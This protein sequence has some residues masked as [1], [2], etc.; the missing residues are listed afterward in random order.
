MK[1]SFLI[2]VTS[3]AVRSNQKNPSRT[4]ADVC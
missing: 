4:Q 2:I 1:D 3:P